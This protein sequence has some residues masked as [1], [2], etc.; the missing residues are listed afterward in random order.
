MTPQHR[1]DRPH[2]LPARRLAR[3]SRTNGGPTGASFGHARIGDRD[4]ALLV[5]AAANDN[6]PSLRWRLSRLAAALG[7]LTLCS[8]LVLMLD[9]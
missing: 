4:R 7:I 9:G 5:S 3:G 2:P 1:P 8:T 6:Q